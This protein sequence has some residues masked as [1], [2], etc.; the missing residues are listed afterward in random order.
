MISEIT[1]FLLRLNRKM[2]FDRTKTS[3]IEKCLKNKI[4]QT[5][6]VIRYYHH[7]AKINI[8]NLW[9]TYSKFRK[10][11]QPYTQICCY[12]RITRFWATII[13]CSQLC[14][15]YGL[16]YN[17]REKLRTD[18]I[19]IHRSCSHPPLAL[20]PTSAGL[21]H[22]TMLLPS[23]C[24]SASTARLAFVLAR[25]LPDRVSLNP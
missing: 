22:P 10:S 5:R 8:I 24:T 4:E 16:S 6:C 23:T 13:Y 15:R 1:P 20:Q 3:N 12:N 7:Q 25:M 18:N 9:A 11:N 14:S 17:L 21:I 2:L 19:L